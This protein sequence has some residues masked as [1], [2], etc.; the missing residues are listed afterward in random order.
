MNLLRR[1]ISLMMKR[2]GAGW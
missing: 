1:G 2:C